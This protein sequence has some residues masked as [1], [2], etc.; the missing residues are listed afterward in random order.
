MSALEDYFID[1]GIETAS[2][3]HKNVSDKCEFGI[4]CPYCSDKN[5][6]LGIFLNNTGFSCFRCKTK[7]SLFR[8]LHD[9]FE[10]SFL[11]Y[12]EIVDLPIIP[13]TSTSEYLRKKIEKGKSNHYAAESLSVSFP[14]N[15]FYGTKREHR[16]A[17]KLTEQ[18]L[19]SRKNPISIKNIK[20]YGCYP[21]IRGEY[22]RRLIM[23]IK[24]IRG[25]K[26]TFQ[27]RDLTNKAVVPYRNPGDVEIKDHLYGIDKINRS[28]AI[29]VEGIFDKWRI[30]NNSVG[31]FGV[32]LSSKQIELLLRKKIKF[33]IFAWDYDA[34]AIAAKTAR[35]V[36]PFF[37]KIKVLDFP[38]EQDPD[39]F[40]RKGVYNLINQTRVFGSLV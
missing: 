35:E 33:L 18:F 13:E 8:L 10:I 2:P 38:F 7:G 39:L 29:I 5:F 20:R 4:C 19:S 34:Y 11:Q 16:I 21:C 37:E 32:G 17:L 6:H 40:G 12:K 3:G 26:K 9:L 1:N 23:P 36:Q 30:G 15:A 22:K 31:T 27:A 14:P 28:F 25:V 24:D